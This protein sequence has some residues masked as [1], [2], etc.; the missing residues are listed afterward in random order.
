MHTFARPKTSRHQRRAASPEECESGTEHK[1][2]DRIFLSHGQETCEKTFVEM[3]E[4]GKTGN[5]SKE[6]GNEEENEK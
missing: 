1:I 3:R 2:H 6:K 4:R 5:G